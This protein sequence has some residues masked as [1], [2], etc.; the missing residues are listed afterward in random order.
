MSQEVKALPWIIKY[1][2]KHVEEVVDQEEAKSQFLTWIESWVRGKVPEKRAVL[3]YGPPGV[4]KTSL[5]E[6]VVRDYN[7]ELLELNAS[8]YRRAED[9]RKT[10]GVAAYRRPLFGKLTL[11]LLDEVD[12]MSA[13]GDAGGLEELLRIIPT[14]QNPIVLTANDPWGDA[15]RP[16]RD[17]VLMIQF[18]ELPLNAVVGLLQNICNKE[19]IE[20]DRE[21]LRYIAEKNMGDVRACVND[22]E[23]VAEGYGKVTMELAR[24]LVRGRDKSIDLWRTLNGVFYAKEG[25]QAKRAI[26][27]SE[28]DYE[29]VMA[30]LNDN[31]PNKYGDPEDAYRAWDALSRASLFLSRS[32]AGNWDLLSY[33]FDLM[34]PGVA[35]A[36]K[37]GE[38][39]KNRYSYPARITLMAKLRDVRQLRDS[40]ASKIAPRLGVSQSLF[41][42]DVLPYL[43]IMFRQG[44]IERAAGM[45]VSYDLSEQEVQYLAGPRAKDIMKAAERIR[46]ELRKGGGG[47]KAKEEPKPVAEQPR[48]ERKGQLTLDMFGLPASGTPSAS[49]KEKRGTRRTRRASGSS[50]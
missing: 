45:V 26:T 36:R 34:G 12:G 41:K 24:A 16:L 27:N 25:W 14:T 31:I 49:E 35:I 23:A 8:D 5:V 28:E 18:K 30:W 19:G 33:V 44:D 7:L 13:K 50:K 2:P 17:Q 32:K 21:A 3:L 10:V 20:C 1:R 46:Q 6:A 48:Q 11:I 22:L 40:V 38:L 43:F 37:S 42:S 47:R 9:I 15:L 39:L 29:T 4:G